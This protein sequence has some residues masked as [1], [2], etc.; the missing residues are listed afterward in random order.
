MP[1]WRWPN[2]TKAEMACRCKCGML[3]TPGFM[4][5][6]QELRDAVGFPLAVSS[7]ARC[8]AHNAKESH[9]GETGPHTTGNAAD[10]LVAGDRAFK[11]VAEATRLKFTGIGISQKGPHGSRFVHVDILSNGPGCPRP[12]VWSY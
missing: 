4:D 5:K 8:P 3:P 9:T 10:L 2:F 7:G 1:D 11:V 12:F 6:L